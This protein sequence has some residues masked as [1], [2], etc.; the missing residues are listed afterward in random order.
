MKI[1]ATLTA[2]MLTIA[3][4]LSAQ[5][6]QT[7]VVINTDAG[8]MK[9]IL[10][11]DTPNHL[12]A[13]VE[14]AQK[15]AYNGTLFTRVIKDFMIQGGSPDSKNAKASARVGLGDP[16]SEILPEFLPNHF[17][18]K[19]AL[20]APRRPDEVN[21]EKKSDM[22]QFYIA[23]GKVY[24]EDELDALES[25]HNLAARTAAV[26]KYREPLQDKLD[27]LRDSDIKA[28]HQLKDSIDAQIKA[29]ILAAPGHLLLS[30]E[31]R[32]AYTTVGGVPTLDGEYT[33]YGEITEGLDVLDK[34]AAAPKDSNDRPT[35]DI[36]IISVTIE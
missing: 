29:A 4:A 31:Q 2:A 19:G 24:T 23:Q 13:F 33:V 7:T 20:C 9:A 6:T 5:T 15:G 10:Y 14:K 32:D 16:A 35:T 28:Y 34:I 18:K 22:S 11:P 17:H 30:K 27:D 1:I 26:Q 36:H 12:K 21:P 8:T 25:Q 3:T